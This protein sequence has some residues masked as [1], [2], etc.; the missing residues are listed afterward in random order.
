MSEPRL[1]DREVR[2]LFSRVCRLRNSRSHSLL[3]RVWRLYSSS[4]L[5]SVPASTSFLRMRGISLRSSRAVVRQVGNQQVGQH[6]RSSADADVGHGLARELADQENQAAKP[7]GEPAVVGL[8]VEI[9]DRLVDLAQ[10]DAGSQQVRVKLAEDEVRGDDGAERR[11]G[12]LPDG[13]MDDLELCAKLAGRAG[14][15]H[16]AKHVLPEPP[17]DRQQRVVVHDD[18]AVFRARGDARARKLA[19][20]FAGVGVEG[21]FDGLPLVGLL[22]QHHA[23]GDR[24]HVG[25]GEFHRNGEPPG[26]ALEQWHVAGQGR[27]ARA[28]QQHSAVKLL[29]EGL[30]NFLHVGRP[31]WD[32]CR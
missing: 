19:V 16:R 27:L 25:V 23:A 14:H 26:E 2:S 17:A 4:S 12:R 28:D 13:F 15:V 9:A 24:L 11:L 5:M 20:D 21:V 6:L 3:S 30:G 32:R 18:I 29:A 31:A 10:Q 8:V 1:L 22:R 7:L